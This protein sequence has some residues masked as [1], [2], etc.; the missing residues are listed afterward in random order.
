M[1]RNGSE[2]CVSV[3]HGVKLFEEFSSLLHMMRKVVAFLLQVFEA[4]RTAVP[5]DT[6]KNSSIHALLKK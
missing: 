3:E 4:N 5:T 1:E 6:T 2:H